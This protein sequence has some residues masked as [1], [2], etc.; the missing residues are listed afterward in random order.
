MVA[1]LVQDPGVHVGVGQRHRDPHL[2]V[3]GE[4]REPLREDTKPHCAGDR[5]RTF[6]ERV[7]SAFF[8]PLA[9]SYAVALLASMLVALTVMPAL[10]FMLLDRVAL[11]RRRSPLADW[12]RRRYEAGL[13]RIEDRPGPAYVTVGLITLAGIVAW[14][15]LGQELL[16]EFKERDFLMHWVTTPGTSLPEMTVITTRVQNEIRSIPGVTHTGAHI[17]QALIME[18]IAD[19]ISLRIGSAS[20]QAPTMTRP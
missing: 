12:L 3:A 6:H 2:G 10:S 1:G 4:P 15:H 17:G 5:A 7:C 11:E 20:T 19:P 8:Q 14:P 16:P 13:R 9:V 18:E